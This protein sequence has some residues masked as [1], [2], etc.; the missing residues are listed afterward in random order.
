MHHG[1][2]PGRHGRPGLRDAASRLAP[3]PV[4]PGM[5]ERVTGR[6]FPMDEPDPRG[7]IDGA[8]LASIDRAADDLT[9]QVI[10]ERL[11]VAKRR[12][13]G[14]R[15]KISTTTEVVEEVAEVEL[16]RY[17]VE[18]T[19][20]PVGRIVD[21]A[22]LARTEGDTTIVP[23]IEERFVVVKQLF[24]KEELHIRH[25][26]EREVKREPVTLRRQRAT[27]DRLDTD[28]AGPQPLDRSAAA[29]S[30]QATKAP[31]R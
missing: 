23:V 19:R 26:V 12:V 14:G 24:L 11:A 9:L 22:P 27:V 6:T 1:S 28:V 8:D 18:V 31:L 5:G 20:L 4:P 13:A 2:G 10:E 25:V 17:R 7:E 30:P 29:G 21:E 16:D 3:G 15:V